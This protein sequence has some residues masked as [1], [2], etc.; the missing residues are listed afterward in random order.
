MLATR[1]WAPITSWITGWLTLVGNWTVTLSINFSGGQLILSAITLWNEDFVP[2]AWQTVLMFWCVMLICATVNIVGVRYLDW[3][4]KICI[5]WTGGSV[6]IILVTL[7][8]M[9]DT[10]RSGE[11]VFAN[12]DASGSGYPE[13]FT[14]F[15]GLLQGAYVLTG[16]GMVGDSFEVESVSREAHMADTF[17]WL[18]CAKKCKIQNGRC[19]KPSCSLWQLPASLVLF[20]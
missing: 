14:F 5:Y 8:S 19:L 6:I 20:T 11:F 15:V 17:R 10:Y 1:E 9:S 16:Y 4:N 18:Q 13:G 7:L 2:N 12:Y 3:I